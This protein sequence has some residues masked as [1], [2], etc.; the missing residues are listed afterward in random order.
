MVPTKLF[1]HVFCEATILLR[2]KS[3]I[4]SR[5]NLFLFV[6]KMFSSFKSRWQIFL[7]CRYLTPLRICKKKCKFVKGFNSIKYSFSPAS[8]K[9]REV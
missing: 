5:Q 4:F 6:I 7:E 8:P 1:M 3:V 2:P 9:C